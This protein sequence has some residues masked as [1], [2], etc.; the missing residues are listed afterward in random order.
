MLLCDG[1][2][3]VGMFASMQ[4]GLYQAALGLTEKP[5]PLL[6]FGGVAV[7]VALNVAWTV[8]LALLV[9]RATRA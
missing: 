3:L 8:R 2:A 6:M 5:D 7:V 1:L 4:R 9:R